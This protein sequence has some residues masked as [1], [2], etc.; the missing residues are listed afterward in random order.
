MSWRTLLPWGTTVM[1]ASVMYLAGRART[2]RWA[3][4][5]GLLN[6]VFWISYAVLAHAYGFIGG[7]LIYASI[8]T[9]NLFR[10]EA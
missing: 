10:K 2:R 1:G 7:S 3:W 8:Y 5:I 9:R 4:V 6:Q